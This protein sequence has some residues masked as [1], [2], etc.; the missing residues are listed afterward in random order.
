MKP[1]PPDSNCES[2]P[3]M[4]LFWIFGFGPTF[5]HTSVE[6]YNQRMRKMKTKKMDF[7]FMFF[8]YS[9]VYLCLFAF[10]FHFF[11]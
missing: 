9:M 10:K 2:Y 8:I 11:V 4:I 5:I 3:L 7:V 6:F 1:C